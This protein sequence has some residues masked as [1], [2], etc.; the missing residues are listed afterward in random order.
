MTIR[1]ATPEDAAL[2]TEMR[3]RF[4]G[5]SPS[6]SDYFRLRQNC[7]DYFASALPQGRCDAV[8]AEV[9]GQCI[10]TGVIFYYDSMPST[11]NPEGRNA[12]ITSMYVEPEYRRRGIARQMLQYLV[13]RAGEKGYGVIM[14][15]ASDMGRPL[16]EQ[17]GFEALTRNMLLDTRKTGE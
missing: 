15:S 5:V 14:L 8:L 17:C 10:G 3:L 11:F 4:M 13:S 1:Y 16:Y 2:L 12:Y 6:R 7:S 9:D